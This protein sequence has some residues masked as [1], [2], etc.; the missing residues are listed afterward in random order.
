MSLFSASVSS[1]LGWSSVF[2]SKFGFPWVAVQVLLLSF[3][4]ELSFPE[5]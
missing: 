5:V 1:S 3:G 4:L 2:E